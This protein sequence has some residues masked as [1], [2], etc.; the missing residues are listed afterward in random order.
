MHGRRTWDEE[1][2]VDGESPTPL[3]SPEGARTGNVRV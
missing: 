1:A 3:S 2:R